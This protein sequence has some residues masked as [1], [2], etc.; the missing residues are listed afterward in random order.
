MERIE[1]I[2]SNLIVSFEKIK[3]N[4]IFEFLKYFYFQIKYINSLCI[5]WSFNFFYKIKIISFILQDKCEDIK[6]DIY[7]YFS[8]CFSIYPF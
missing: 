7:I 3:V 4:E 6:I 2:F 8:F 1:F 5:I